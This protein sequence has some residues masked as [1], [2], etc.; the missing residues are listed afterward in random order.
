MRPRGWFTD[1]K[2]SDGPNRN[3]T[4][5][6]INSG[7]LSGA[8]TGTPVIGPLFDAHLGIPVITWVPGINRLLAIVYESDPVDEPL[9]IRGIPRVDLRIK[10]SRA[11]AQ[12]I[13]HL[14]DVDGLGFGRLITH[15]PMTL[16]DAVPGKEV[17]L[18]V[19]LVAAAYDVPEGH[20]IAVAI[21]TYD[22]QYGVPTLAP[23]SIRLVHD[24]DHQST[25][26]LP[27]LRQ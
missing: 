24:E 25:L 3:N 5:N 10:P 9:R 8:T 1:A 19:D 6:T 14:Y 16:W 26:E 12:L 7:I 11:Q 20:R 4:T 2:L 15:G 18:S 17:A 27:L 22:P 13:V 21:D 23:Y